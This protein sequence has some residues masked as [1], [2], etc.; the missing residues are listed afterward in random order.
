[1][2]TSADQLSTEQIISAIASPE[3]ARTGTSLRSRVSAPSSPQGHGSG[4][5]AESALAGSREP[6][7]ASRAPRPVL[8][9]ED[10]DMPYIDKTPSPLRRLGGRMRCPQHPGQC[11]FRAVARPIR[12]C[13]SSVSV[14]LP[15]MSGLSPPSCRLLSLISAVPS[16]T[17]GRACCR[18]PALSQLVVSAAKRYFPRAGS[19]ILLLRTVMSLRA[20]SS[21]IRSTMSECLTGL[22]L[23]SGSGGSYSAN[24]SRETRVVLRWR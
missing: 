3:P 22:H 18:L 24:S 10:G 2:G 17:R 23:P 20:S 21:C 16:F 12:C 9:G 4:R 14:C 8:P 6:R 13:S 11:S 19:R 15:P 1:M 5:A 7:L